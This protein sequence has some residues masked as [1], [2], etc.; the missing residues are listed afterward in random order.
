MRF[1]RFD[2]YDKR[3]EAVAKTLTVVE[4]VRQKVDTKAITVE[5][6]ENLKVR[7][8]QELEKLTSIG[9]TIPLGDS[10]TI[11][12]R[13]LLTEMRNTKLLGSGSPTEPTPPS[14]AR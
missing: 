4:M 2:T 3:I 10:A 14:E 6:G 13:Q 7:I 1:W 8:L 5:E 9:A 12:Q 11:D